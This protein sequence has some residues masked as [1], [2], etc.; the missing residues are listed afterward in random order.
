MCIRA[1]RDAL[2]SKVKLY[3][4]FPCRNLLHWPLSIDTWGKSNVVS[5]VDFSE[6]GSP[7]SRIYWLKLRDRNSS[8]SVILGTCGDVKLLEIEFRP[9]RLWTYSTLFGHLF[10]WYE[11]RET[12]GDWRQVVF[13]LR[14]LFFPGYLS[15]KVS[16][17]RPWSFCKAMLPDPL[18]WLL[19]KVDNA[20]IAA[21]VSSSE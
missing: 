12:R 21:S 5:V 13:G 4:T 15:S 3:P 19:M 9:L 17:W 2:S 7:Q 11:R 8:A 6:A 18:S 16:C 10:I 14:W 20:P 1:L